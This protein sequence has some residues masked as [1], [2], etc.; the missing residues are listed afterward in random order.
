MCGL[1]RYGGSRTRVCLAG[2][3]LRPTRR[4]CPGGA[5][6]G[7]RRGGARRETGEPRLRWPPCLAPARPRDVACKTMRTASEASRSRLPVRGWRSR[8][9][10]T[11]PAFGA[12]RILTPPYVFRPE[13]SH[14]N[15]VLPCGSLHRAVQPIFGGFPCNGTLCGGARQ[16]TLRGGGRA[17]PHNGPPAGSRPFRIRESSCRCP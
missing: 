12:P 5:A 8:V 7:P 13:A 17:V 10:G 14:V 6:R 9:R 11:E 4:A 16:A 1:Y 3:G 15:G 2:P